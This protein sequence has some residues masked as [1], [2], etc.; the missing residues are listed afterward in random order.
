MTLTS[1]LLFLIE[2]NTGMVELV[3]VS[4]TDNLQKSIYDG[5]S[6]PLVKCWQYVRWK[7]NN[8][9]FLQDLCYVYYAKMYVVPVL[10]SWSLGKGTRCVLTCAVRY[11][12][13]KHLSFSNLS[14]HTCSTHC[15]QH[16]TIEN[17]LGSMNILTYLND[18][19]YGS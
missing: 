16:F 19:G 5:H 14:W 1:T 7:A 3:W 9:L 12:L 18:F 15:K 4:I 13:S 6:W 11:W 8:P 10:G 2:G 17:I